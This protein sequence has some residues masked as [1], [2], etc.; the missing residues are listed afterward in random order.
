MKVFFALISCAG[1]LFRFSPPKMKCCALLVGVYCAQ[2][3]VHAQPGMSQDDLSHFLIQ[4]RLPENASDEQAILEYALRT[5][6]EAYLLRVEHLDAEVHGAVSLCLAQV[7]LYKDQTKCSNYLDMAFSRGCVS[8]EYFVCLLTCRRD[9]PALSRLN[10]IEGGLAY[11]P[12]NTW[13]HLQK[14]FVLL[15][16]NRAQEAEQAYLLARLNNPDEENFYAFQ[17]IERLDAVDR[18]L[19]RHW[20]ELLPLAKLSHPSMA[21]IMRANWYLD[22]WNDPAKALADLDQALLLVADPKFPEINGGNKHI[23]MKKGIALFALGEERKAIDLWF[24]AGVY[25]VEPI[26]QMDVDLMFSLGQRKYRDVFHLIK[27]MGNINAATFFDGGEQPWMDEALNH[28]LK[29]KKLLPHNGYID[30]YISMLHFCKG[31]YGRAS[32]SFALAEKSGVRPYYYRQLKNK[33][34]A[35]K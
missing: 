30:Y 8:Q 6:N 20:A 10:I 26:E 17:W 12:G 31:Q 14:A 35:R 9:F 2:F 24:K 18:E 5:S 11:L 23:L 1:M 33:M 29:S 3:N 25:Y 7:Y 4:H 13:L 19:A 15:E 22:R 28:A 34:E 32:N 21:Y 16:L 27:D